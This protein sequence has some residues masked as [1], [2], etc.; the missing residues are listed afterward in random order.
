MEYRY[1]IALIMAF[2]SIIFITLRIVLRKSNKKKMLQILLGL[3]VTCLAVSEMIIL[4]NEPEGK[5]IGHWYNVYTGLKVS[6]V[7]DNESTANHPTVF[8]FSWAIIGVG[9]G[10]GISILTSKEKSIKSKKITLIVFGFLVVFLVLMLC[11]IPYIRSMFL[12]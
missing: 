7:Y 6:D 8:V 3:W 1:L 5:I 9:F 10:Y 4:F 11:L 12:P 2:V